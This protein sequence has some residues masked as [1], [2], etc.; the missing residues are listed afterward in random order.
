MRS[1]LRNVIL[2]ELQL[3]RS[4]EKTDTIDA[5]REPQAIADVLLKVRNGVKE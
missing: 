4:D 1:Q 2:W 5:K 3:Q